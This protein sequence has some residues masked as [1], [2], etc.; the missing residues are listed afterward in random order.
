MTTSVWSLLPSISAPMPFQL[1][2][3]EILFRDL[4][5]TCRIAQEDDPFNLRIHAPRLRFYYAS[6]PSVSIGALQRAEGEGPVIRRL[7]GGGVVRHGRDF[8]F[9]LVAR[10]NHD[11]SFHSVRISY[12]KI[13]E[14][15]KRA[16]ELLGTPPR[17][18]RCDENLPSGPDCFKYPIASDLALAGKKIAGGAQKRSAGTLLHE[19][20]IQGEGRDLQRFEGP[21]IQGLSEIFGVSIVKEPIRPDLLERA[22]R[23]AL[24]KYQ[25]VIQ[26]S[27]VFCDAEVAFS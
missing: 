18:Y 23:L 2:L 5:E 3:N 9:T 16:L 26:P 17:F 22:S 14:A 8:L 12:C 21:L 4:E 20:S 11:E 15:V 24:E 10:K 19:E 27:S 7:T 1:A 25:P 13:H 6:E